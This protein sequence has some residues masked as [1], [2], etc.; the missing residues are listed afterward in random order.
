HMYKKVY[1]KAD[2]E[3]PVR[4]SKLHCGRLCEEQLL[5]ERILPGTSEVLS[6]EP[7]DLKICCGKHQMTSPGLQFRSHETKQQV[8]A[9]FQNDRKL[10]NTSQ[11]KSH[12]RRISFLKRG[13]HSGTA[14]NS[15]K[16]DFGVLQRL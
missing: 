11:V 6:S 1:Y 10:L 9:R 2:V 16:R 13:E 12:H 15:S 7:D 8:G 4:I 5:D 3:R 14:S